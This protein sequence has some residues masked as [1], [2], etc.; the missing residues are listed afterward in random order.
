MPVSSSLSSISA[1]VGRFFSLKAN[2][3]DSIMVALLVYFAV[4]A[5]LINCGV[6][7]C[8]QLILAY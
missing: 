3:I 7:I 2:S 6:F 4:F 5:D 8:R 1:T